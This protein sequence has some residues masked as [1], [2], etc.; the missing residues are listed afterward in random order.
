MSLNFTFGI[1]IGVIQKNQRTQLTAKVLQIMFLTM[2][3]SLNL[4]IQCYSF[5]M[6]IYYLA[7]AVYIVRYLL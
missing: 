3:S 7:L 4:Y 5:D 1:F 2:K 6:Y